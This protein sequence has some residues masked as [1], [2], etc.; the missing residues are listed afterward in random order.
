MK[1]IVI[2]VL[3]ILSFAASSF[4]A[5]TMRDGYWELITTMEM[6][7]MPM[8]MPPTKLK[9]CYSKDD[10][11]D[12]KKTITTD[13]DCTVTDLKQSGNKVTWKMKCTGKNAGTFSGETVYRGDA[14]DS[15]MKMQT[16]GQ[17]MNMKINAKR[18]GNCP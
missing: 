6:P 15:T 4:A 8:K 3:S 2:A 5:D 7:G 18:L 1:K 12:Q 9:H 14:Y 10:V 13:K 16:Q 17:T 11:K